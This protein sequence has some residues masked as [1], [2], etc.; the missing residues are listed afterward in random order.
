MVGGGGSR[1]GAGQERW[2][3]RSGGGGRGRNGGQGGMGVEAGVVRHLY[4]ENEI[5][6]IM[7][8]TVKWPT[9]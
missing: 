3:G 7:L 5:L 8:P 4:K 1:L 6:L 9:A 2:L